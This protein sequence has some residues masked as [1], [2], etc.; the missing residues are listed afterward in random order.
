MKNGADRL[1]TVLRTHAEGLRRVAA[2]YARPSDQEDLAQDIA[3]ALWNAL[4]SFRGE[5]SERT[6]VYRV[7][8]NRGVNHLVRRRPSPE[9]STEIADGT[10]SPEAMASER[11][12][13]E[14][15]FCGIR[16]LPV[17]YRQVLTLALEELSHDEIGACLGITTTNVAVRLKRA[18][19]A[20]RRQLEER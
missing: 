9:P 17:P 18:R 7:A 15:L 10:P 2:A 8:H 1:A 12:Q 20:L 11:Q 6:F 14:H 5:C 13:I 3:L 4:P 16:A 19:D